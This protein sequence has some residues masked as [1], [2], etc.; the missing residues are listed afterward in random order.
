MRSRPHVPDGVWWQW[1]GDV[2]GCNIARVWG[3]SAGDAADLGLYER[4]SGW[5]GYEAVH[6]Q[7]VQLLSA[8]V[9]DVGEDFV[10]IVV[11]GE[12]AS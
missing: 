9:V 2:W 3:R 6:A 5:S 1:A 11:Y 8:H 4:A 10:E 12:V 7:D